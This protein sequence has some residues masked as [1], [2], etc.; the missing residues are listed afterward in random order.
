MKTA[1]F[2]AATLLLFS[3]STL[4]VDDDSYYLACKKSRSASAE[5]RQAAVAFLVKGL[6]GAA[7]GLRGQLLGY[8]QDFAP[9]DFDAESRSALAALLTTPNSP[10][11]GKLVLLAGYLNIGRDELYRQYVAP[12]LPAKRK[13]S[14]ALALARMGDKKALS[15]CV[16]KVKKAPVDNNLVGYVLP[17]L[18]YTR[19]K[20]AADYCVELLYSDEQGCR[21]ANPDAP[22]AIPCAYRLI[23]LLAPV[24]VD[25]PVKVNPAIGL[26][27]DSYPETL[28]AVRDWLKSHPDYKIQNS[29]F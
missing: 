10:H 12:E 24:I 4:A 21:S 20:A 17:D 14:L 9:A 22:E 11:Y 29:R 7:S 25:F 27:S 6:D 28:Q 18:L 3:N 19:Q 1:Y 5:E 2:L 8:L 23:E 16:E 13:W 26:E 15:Y